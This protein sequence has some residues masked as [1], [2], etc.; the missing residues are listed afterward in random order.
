[1]ALEGRAKLGFVETPREIACL[2]VDLAGVGRDAAVL[3]AGCGRGVFLQVL[4]F[5]LGEGGLLPHGDVLFIQPYN[6]EDTLWLL[7]YL[8]SN[9]FREYYLSKGPRRGGRLAFTQKML[10]EVEVPVLPEK[11]KTQISEIVKEILSNANTQTLEKELD[12][13]MINI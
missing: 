3:D 10:E 11:T 4:K 1:M 5:S 9:L 13:L 8:N 6:E 2:M 12:R 7:S